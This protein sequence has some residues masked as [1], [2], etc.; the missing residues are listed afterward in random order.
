MTEL[1]KARADAARAQAAGQPPGRRQPVPLPLDGFLTQ[2]GGEQ[3]FTNLNVVADGAS[4]ATISLANARP[5][6]FFGWLGAARD[7]RDRRRDR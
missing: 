6:A 3:G 7:A 5:Q 2:S 4:R 1:G